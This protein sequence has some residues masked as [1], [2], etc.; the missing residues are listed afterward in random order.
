MRSKVKVSWGV[1]LVCLAFSMLLTEA[2]YFIKCAIDKAQNREVY[3]SVSDNFLL[4]VFCLMIFFLSYMAYTTWI[5]LRKEISG[6]HKRDIKSYHEVTYK[7]FINVYPYNVVYKMLC[8]EY[9]IPDTSKLGVLIKVN[10]DGFESALEKYLSRDERIL[11][12][13]I[14]RDGNT[15]NDISKRIE[16]SVR[17][18]RIAEEKI[19]SKISKKRVRD[20]Y[21]MVSMKSYL[22]ME[23]EY[24]SLRDTCERM[25]S[26]YPDRWKRVK[27][28]L[29]DFPI[30]NL[31]MSDKV[32]DSLKL[33]GID[34]VD[35]LKGMSVKSLSEVN[36]LSIEGVAEVVGTLSSLGIKI[37]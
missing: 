10:P 21:M 26:S 15:L 16:L 14:Y 2:I 1:F 19:L 11:I 20:H 18:L 17:E 24:E 35:D 22:S 32:T 33:S 5:R 7:D 6:Q 9:W 37:Y 29:V 30:E 27:M 28:K 36:G 31:C 3:R 8:G 34:K 25:Y 13:S 4:F 12:R 23:L